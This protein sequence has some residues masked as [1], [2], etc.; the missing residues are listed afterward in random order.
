MKI[1][2]LNALN[3]LNYPTFLNNPKCNDSEIVT[4]KFNYIKNTK[5]LKKINIDLVNTKK[6]TFPRQGIKDIS[7]TDSNNLR[8]SHNL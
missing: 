6:I 8:K 3:Y 5:D 4:Q 7:Q 1:Y 2:L